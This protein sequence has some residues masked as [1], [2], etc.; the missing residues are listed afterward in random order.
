MRKL[1]ET[2]SEYNKE[3]DISA[4]MGNRP[5]GSIGIA[6]VDAVFDRCDYNTKEIKKWAML[7]KISCLEKEVRKQ[8]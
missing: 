1:E 2:Y 5:A 3:Y 8:H 6:I 7:Q 4:E